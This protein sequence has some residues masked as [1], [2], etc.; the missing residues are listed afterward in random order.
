MFVVDAYARRM[1]E[2]HGLAEAR[3]DYEYLRHFFEKNLP[4]DAA[5]YNEFHALIVHAGK[6]Y[7]RAQN[8]RCSACALH[9]LLPENDVAST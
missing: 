6:R 2:R 8:P 7:C 5:L 9:S 1:L 4:A 3:H